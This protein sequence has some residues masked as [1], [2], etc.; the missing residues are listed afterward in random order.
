M[1][2]GGI[3]Y[4]DVLAKRINAEQRQQVIDVNNTLMELYTGKMVIDD[5]ALSTADLWRLVA[6]EKP[7]LLIVDH[8]RLLSDRAD[9]ET[10][11]LGAITWN[12]K[13]IAKEFD[14]AVIALAQLNR[15]LE[16]RG[17]RSSP[18]LQT[19]PATVARLKRTQIWY[20]GY[21]GIWCMWIAIRTYPRRQ[22]KSSSSEMD[23]RPSGSD[24]CLMGLVNGSRRHDEN[25][26]S[27]RDVYEFIVLYWRKHL[28][29]P[30]IR[31]IVDGSILH[32]TSRARYIVR[33]L[34]DDGLMMCTI[35]S[36]A[37]SFPMD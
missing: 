9:N 7:D 10:H 8:I 31:E 23:P 22:L 25:T 3:A 19:L 26:K 17:Q 15:Q 24:C 35:A 27:K 37:A 34:Q 6:S 14:I 11:R 21:T 36:G 30:S 20:S 16:S 32:S 2:H 28:V 18:R 1:R 29:S 5:R 13:K 4:R 33:A 12:L